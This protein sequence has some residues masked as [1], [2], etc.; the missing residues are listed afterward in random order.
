MAVCPHCT[1]QVPPEAVVCPVCGRNLQPV[2]VTVVVC[3]KPSRLRWTSPYLIAA[4][5]LLGI[6]VAM[7]YSGVQQARE[8][9]RRSSCKCN[10]KILGLALQ[11]YHDA[12]G[13]FPP[14]WIA[15]SQGRPMH[16]WRVLL[17]PYIDQAALY[18]RYNFAEPWDGP[19]N[20]KLLD[21]IPPVYKCPSHVP[22]SASVAAIFGP[23]GPLAC[24]TGATVSGAARRKCTNYA[25]VLGRHCAFRGADPVSIEDITDGTSSTLMIGE[26]TDADIL[27]TKPEDIDVS[28]HPQIGDR[29]GFSSDHASGAQFATAA[30]S[31]RFIFESIP[32]ETVDALYTRD[33]GEKIRGW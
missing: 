7:L 14:A 6:L 17:L 12:H 29:M 28:K 24:S 26:V 8:A 5:S 15:D 27:W 31:V 9:A 11:T 22:R 23:F 13:C 18:S 30:G 32:Q 1:A 10:L 21:E 25:A 19:N 4:T 20:V 16:S 2:G 3:Q 33:R